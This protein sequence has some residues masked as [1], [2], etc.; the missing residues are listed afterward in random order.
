M[1]QAESMIIRCGACGVKNK[2]PTGKSTD[3]AKCGKCGTHLKLESQKTDPIG[4]YTIRCLECRAKNRVPANKVNA[5]PKCGKCHVPLK[6]DDLFSPQP[7]MV[8]DDNFADTVL[9]SSLPV[10]LFCWAN[11]CPTCGAVAPII[12]EFAAESKGKVRVGKLNVD[13]NP[14]VAAKFNVLSVPFLFIFDNGQLKESMPGGL[15][16]HELMMKL[17]PYL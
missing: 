4:T 17:A 15:Q 7:V 3:V 13:S 12:D 10:L 11:W 14:A 2:I 5:G 16:K 8:T 1:N 6:T 9:K